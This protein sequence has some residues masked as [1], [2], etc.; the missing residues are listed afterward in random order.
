MKRCLVIL[1]QPEHT[2][3]LLNAAAQ[4]VALTAI[5]RVDVLACRFGPD[6]QEQDLP[7][8]EI[9]V[10]EEQQ[11]ARLAVLHTQFCHWL[12]SE[13]HHDRKQVE[14]TVVKWLETE[15]KNFEYIKEFSKKVDI[16]LAAM[17]S[18]ELALAMH[19]GGLHTLESMVF[20]IPFEP[21]TA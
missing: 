6:Q 15:I 11:R 17:P 2:K 21:V 16:V 4:L 9:F 19:E 5:Q 13:Y 12:Q 20:L 14:E 18:E 1:D 3:E 7:P 8:A 10:F